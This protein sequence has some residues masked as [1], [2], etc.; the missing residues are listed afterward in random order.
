MKTRL[1]LRFFTLL[2]GFCTLASGCW[3]LV[4]ALSGCQSRQLYKDSRM[5]LGPIV[6]LTSADKRAAEIAFKEIARIEN[7]LSRYKEQSEVARLNA[8]G[9]ISASQETLYLFEKAGE[10]WQASQ[11]AF[12]ITVA[13]LLA[14]WGFYGLDFRV[15]DSAEIEEARRLIGFDKIKINGNIIE[16]NEIGMQ[17]DLGGIAKGYAVDSAIKKLRRAGINS[18]LINAGGDVYCLGDKNGKPWR[19]AVKAGAK[20]GFADYL[21][22]KDQAVATSGD[23]EKYFSYNGKHYSH[24]LDPRSGR[25]ADSGIS[26]VSVIAADC[27]TADALATSIMIL[28]EEAGRELAES[29]NAEVIIIQGG[30]S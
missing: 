12:D 26:S 25:P 2:S 19:I 7:L 4:S 20:R 13:P 1:W 29:F 17:V 30:V 15:P 5:M 28:G 22:L 8:Q 21:K 11:G 3:L 23:Y 14:L 18:A 10:F 6:E 27:L 24:I 16:F 9:R